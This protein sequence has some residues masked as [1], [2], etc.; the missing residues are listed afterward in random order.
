MILFEI[1][2]S[3]SFPPLF[4]LYFSFLN[5]SKYLTALLFLKLIKPSS[6][7]S[8]HGSTALCTLANNGSLLMVLHRK[9]QNT[10]RSILSRDE[11]EGEIP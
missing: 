11:L 2:S 7:V 1:L 9:I 4:F 10:C 5:I 6:Y 8:F 3:D